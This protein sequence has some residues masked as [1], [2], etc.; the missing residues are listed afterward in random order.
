L[1]YCGEV[2]ARGRL[3]VA[4][5][6]VLIALAVPAA[7]SARVGAHRR[8]VQVI[9][10]TTAANMLFG[11]QGGYRVGIRLEAPDV[12]VLVV[13]KAGLTK[14]A[15]AETRYGAHF[16]G[17][18]AGGRVSADFGPV[19][20]ISLRFRADGPAREG[21]E[22]KQCEGKPWRREV[23]HWVGKISLHGEDDYFAVSTATA[24]G[25][26]QRSFRQRCRFKHPLTLPPPESLRQQVE[27]P[28]GFSIAAIL[29]GTSASL[30]AENNEGGR[31]VVMRAAHAAGRGPGAEVEAG[32]FEYLGRTPVGRIVQNLET[33]PGSLLTTLPGEHPATA[34][35]KPGAPFSGEAS[36]LA[37]SPTDHKWTGTLVVQFPG[38]RV[39]LTGPDFFSTLCVIS[40]LVKPL[41]CEFQEP[42]WQPGEEPNAAAQR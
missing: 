38:L 40:S 11:K 42:S 24:N 7:A 9:Q 8:H 30:E 29:L 18:L 16:R 25:V 12:A 19:G 41:G 17:S 36:Y 23:G 31:T 28:I 39:P 20:S 10:P 4:A 14:L 32:A 5:S 21:R 22:L 3:V 15:V 27:P 26:L 6:V 13:Q 33:P 1:K 34:T 2:K 37:A 35:V